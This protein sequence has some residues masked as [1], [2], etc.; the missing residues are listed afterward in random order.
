VAKRS[1][2]IKTGD[3]GVGGTNRPDVMASRQIVGASGPVIFPCSI[4]SRRWRAVMEEVDKGCS[5]FCVT[6]GSVIRTAD[7]LI[8]SRLKALA[9]NMSRPYGRIWLYAGLI[10]SDNPHWLK[11]DL[12]VC[13]D[14]SSSSWV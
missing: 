5:V 7:I 1:F 10:G 8:H 14:P 13:V 6:V 11:A 9:V 2:G 12:V 3:G 4:K